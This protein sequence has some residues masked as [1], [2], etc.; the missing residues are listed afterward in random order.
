[1]CGPCAASTSR[2][3]PG[4]VHALVGENGAGES[5]L[6][7]VLSGVLKPDEG[8][9]TLGGREHDSLDPFHAQASASGSSTRSRRPWRTSA[10]SRT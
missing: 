10:S 1:M 8:V 3:R 9:I 7:N 2:C 5:T 4:E 6:M